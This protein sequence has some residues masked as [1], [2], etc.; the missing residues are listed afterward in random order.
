[1]HLTTS[2]IKDN[3][4]RQQDA[5]VASS[6]TLQYENKQ[7]NRTHR[8]SKLP[9]R[10]LLS[11]MDPESAVALWASLQVIFYTVSQN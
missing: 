8:Q 4:R 1:M 10:H 9:L 7:D 5:D 6:R 11:N 3:H 2:A